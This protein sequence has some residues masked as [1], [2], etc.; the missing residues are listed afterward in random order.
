MQIALVNLFKGHT[1]VFGYLM[2]IYNK[3]GS[4]ITYF[5]K[6]DNCI[7]YYKYI[8]YF[9]LL[10]GNIN[11]KNI[12][13]LEMSYQQYDIIIFITMT[14]DVPGYIIHH[15][16]KYGIIHN[17]SRKS[18]YINNYIGLYPNQKKNFEKIIKNKLFSYTYPFY[19]T[20]KIINKEYKYIMYIGNVLDNDTDI[21]NFKNNIK[22]EL[23]FFNNRNKNIK[24]NDMEEL[25]KYLEKTL[26]I[27]GKKTY[28]YDNTYSGSVTIS[29]S[30]N[31]PIILQKSKLDEYGID[32][33]GFENNY[34][35]LIDYVNNLD[36][37]EYNNLLTIMNNFKQQEIIKNEKFFL[38]I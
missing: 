31:I 37:N 9:E 15:N 22:Y 1:E 21:I 19:N 30:Y 33:I 18:P 17:S 36:F 11:K 34:S 4:D 8:K 38:N 10:F 16:K 6:D 32:G 23:I 35:E 28:N 5:Y 24:N 27:L 7:D 26:F 14:V 2:E 25:V 13:E 12:Q 29:Y 3:N 20:P